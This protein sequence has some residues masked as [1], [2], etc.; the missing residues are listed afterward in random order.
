MSSL[1]HERE[2]KIKIIKIV[3]II[4]IF[5]IT[6]II[7]IIYYAVTVNHEI[8]ELSL[9]RFFVNLI[10]GYAIEFV[11][12]MILYKLFTH[13]CPAMPLDDTTMSNDDMNVILNIFRRAENIKTERATKNQ[14]MH[15]FKNELY[16]RMK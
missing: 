5:P 7:P 1:Y 3:I 8:I 15:K 14:K 12:L 2:Y 16:S 6:F 4:F 10:I 13:S 9:I 11:G